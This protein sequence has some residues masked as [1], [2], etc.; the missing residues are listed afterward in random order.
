M[1]LKTTSLEVVPTICIDIG[2]NTFHLIGLDKMGA[3]VLRQ[4][5]SRNQV[6]T[7]LANTPRCLVGGNSRRSATMRG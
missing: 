2:K 5:L 3:V 1:Q 7:R 6:D 4:K